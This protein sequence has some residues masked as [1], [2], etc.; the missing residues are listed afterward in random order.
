MLTKFYSYCFQI[1]YIL[2]KIH[3]VKLIM[4]KLLF[5]VKYIFAHCSDQNKHGATFGNESIGRV[6]AVSCYRRNNSWLHKLS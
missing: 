2:F 3:I 5:L 6:S 4:S 1:Y